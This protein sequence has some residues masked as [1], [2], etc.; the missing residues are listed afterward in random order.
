MFTLC[1]AKVRTL[2]R[3]PAMPRAPAMQRTHQSGAKTAPTRKSL[4]AAQLTKEKKSIGKDMKIL[5]M[6]RASC[7]LAWVVV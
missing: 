6:K 1:E 7:L 3:T 4:S 5:H 2:P